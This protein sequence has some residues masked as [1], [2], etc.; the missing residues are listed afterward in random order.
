MSLVSFLIL[1]VI[2]GAGLYLLQL[3]PMDAAIRSIVRVVAIVLL[4][5]M[6]IKM[7][8]PVAGLG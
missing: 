2:V 3:I 4:A 1:C 5:V 8:M 7:L 6:A